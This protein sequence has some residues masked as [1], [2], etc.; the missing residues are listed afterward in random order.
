MAS[1]K[2]VLCTAQ[3]LALHTAR[4]ADSPPVLSPCPLRP[5]RRHLQ[6]KQM[7]QPAFFTAEVA[8]NGRERD[9]YWH[10]GCPLRT[11]VP[12]TFNVLFLDVVDVSPLNGVWLTTFE[13]LTRKAHIGTALGIVPIAP[14]PLIWKVG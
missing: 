14:V 4:L 11:Q 9:V 2:M 5:P 12:A 13:K 6:S 8:G 7:R 10:I 3:D 1:F